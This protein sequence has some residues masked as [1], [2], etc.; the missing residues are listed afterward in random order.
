MD[1]HEPDGEWSR[2]CYFHYRHM[3]PLSTYHCLLCKH[4]GEVVLV[5]TRTQ[6]I[7]LQ[8]EHIKTK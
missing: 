1:I 5:E 8:M 6:S 4:L 3:E 2:I 7:V